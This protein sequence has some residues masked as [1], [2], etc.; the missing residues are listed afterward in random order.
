LSDDI[1]GKRETMHPLEIKGERDLKE[2][3]IRREEKMDED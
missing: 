1:P 2:H 3:M